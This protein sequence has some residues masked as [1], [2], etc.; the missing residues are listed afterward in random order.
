MA[1]Q[2][3][4]A[5]LYD[6][7]SEVLPRRYWAYNV[8]KV[9]KHTES[10]WL[11]EGKALLENVLVLDSRLTSLLSALPG[12]VSSDIV[13]Y[14]CGEILGNIRDHLKHLRA[15]LKTLQ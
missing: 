2:D 1:L 10:A 3:G 15:S 5:D 9:G 8:G 7:L 4:E 11:E 6:Q 13:H 14:S 12:T